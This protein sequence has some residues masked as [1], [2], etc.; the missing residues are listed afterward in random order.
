[1][2]IPSNTKERK[3]YRA[4]INKKIKQRIMHIKREYRT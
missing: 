1:M 3:S 4:Q 2:Y